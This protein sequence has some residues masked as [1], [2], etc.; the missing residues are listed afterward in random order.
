MRVRIRTELFILIRIRIRIKI[1]KKM[2]IYADPDPQP[3]FFPHTGARKISNS[4]GQGEGIKQF[5]RKP[6]IFCV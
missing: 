5:D 2:R 1:P 3:C 6:C 4:E